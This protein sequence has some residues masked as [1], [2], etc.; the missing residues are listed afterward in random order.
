L[1]IFPELDRTP[2]HYACTG[3]HVKVVSMLLVYGA[4]VNARDNVSCISGIVL[5]HL[6]S[7]K[8]PLHL[9]CSK[10]DIEVVSVLLASGA[11]LEAKDKVN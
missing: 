1:L 8:T 10:G 6:Q 3:G 11:P 9:A 7:R 5:N 4:N 2:L